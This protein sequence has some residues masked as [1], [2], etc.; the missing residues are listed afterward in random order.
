M[1]QV[2]FMRIVWRGVALAVLGIVSACVDT[3]VLR[4]EIT[5]YPV[6]CTV[7]M[8]EGRCPQGRGLPLNPTTFSVNED[9][10]AVVANLVGMVTRYTNC[11]I[12]NRRNWQCSYN[13]GAGTFGFDGGQYWERVNPDALTFMSAE[14]FD[15]TFYVSRS[16]HLRYGQEFRLEQ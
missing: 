13:D 14:D 2:T 12:Q 1:A 4:G 16:E 6:R 10:Q 5:S 3:G 8:V 7:P 15:D 9:Q 11:A